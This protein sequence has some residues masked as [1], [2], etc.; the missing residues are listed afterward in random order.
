[1]EC[2]QDVH[3][4]YNERVDAEHEHL[5]WRHPRVHSYYNNARGRVT[6]NMP[7]KLLDYWRMTK[8][9]ALDDFVLSRR[10]RERPARGPGRHRDRRGVRLRA[11]DREPLRREGARVVIVDLD[12]PRGAGVVDEVRAAGTDAR[13][14]VGDVSTLEV[15]EEAVTTATGE[16]GRLDVL[17]NNAGIV[18]GDDRDTWDTTEETWDRLLRVNLRSVYVCSKA[19]IPVMREA[20]GGVDRERGVD[21]GLRVRG[22]R[23]LRGREGRDPEL[24]PS[25]RARAGRSQRPCQ[26]R[27]ARLHAH[28]HD[29]RRAPRARRG[30]RRR[31]ASRAGPGSCRPSGSARWTTSPTRSCTWPAPR[32]GYVTGQEIIVDGAYVVR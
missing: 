27:L 30:G 2:R 10:R 32:P 29:H 17:V 21:R 28:P 11:G 6:T 1:M 20:G 15:A 26:L 3:D 19:A 14:V 5:V 31:R 22:R 25:R 12:E 7:W 13:L 16:F 9:P 23:R 18:Q 4:A 8:E 24:H